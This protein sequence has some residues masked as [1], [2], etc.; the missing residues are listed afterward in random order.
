MTRKA[1]VVVFD[2]ETTGDN[3]SGNDDFVQLA[4]VAF[5]EGDYSTV[6]VFNELAKPQVR[7]SKG[8]YD[9]HGIHES[10]LVDQLPSKQVAGVWWAYIEE[11]AKSHDADIYLAGHNIIGFDI[12]IVSQHLPNW[13]KVK[14]IDTLWAARRIDPLSPNHRLAPLV[15]E[16]Y[17]LDTELPKRAHDGLADCY[18]VAKLLEHY[19]AKEGLSIADF[20][21]WLSTPH[22]LP[23]VPFGKHKGLPFSSLNAGSL[24]WFANL[25]GVQPDIR[26]TALHH[27][28]AHG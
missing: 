22:V 7:I 19:R 20:C 15:G 27:L 21:E 5:L 12:P 10:Q 17:C 9:T 26:L 25:S 28:K 8:A 14:L 18:M 3:R 13:P 4:S 11:F 6:S 24:R 23:L 16:R 1:V 2:T